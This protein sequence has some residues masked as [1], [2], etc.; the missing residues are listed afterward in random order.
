MPRPPL[1]LVSQ[2]SSR[3][4]NLEVPGRRR[5]SV[6]EQTGDVPG[7]HLASLKVKRHQ[8]LSA[9]GVRERC[10]DQLVRVGLPFW[11]SLRHENIFSINAK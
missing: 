6:L 9:R 4:Q 11:F 2:Q 3:Y 7:R 8:D 1:A 10:K 5:P